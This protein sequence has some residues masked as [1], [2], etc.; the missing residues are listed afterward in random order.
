MAEED[1]KSLRSPQDLV[2]KSASED[3]ETQATYTVKLF[4]DE[5]GGNLV[6]GITESF[7]D[8]AGLLSLENSGSFELCS[9]VLRFTLL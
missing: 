3:F 1:P 6:S 9:C 7:V 4:I 8:D 2:I 5:A